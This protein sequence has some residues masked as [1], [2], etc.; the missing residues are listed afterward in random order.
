MRRERRLKTTISLRHLARSHDAVVA[1][2]PARRRG[3][4]PLQLP[5]PQAPRRRARPRHGGALRHLLLPL[6]RRLPRAPPR[7]RRRP[8]RE[9]QPAVRGGA[10]GW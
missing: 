2:A 5:R 4:F 7:H 6:H 1:I 3:G 8:R 9:Q 10:H